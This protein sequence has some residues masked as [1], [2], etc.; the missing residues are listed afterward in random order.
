MY[1]C[2]MRK[3]KKARLSHLHKKAEIRAY[4]ITRVGKW[5]VKNN[6]QR[7]EPCVCVLWKALAFFH[8]L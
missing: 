3:K 2:D 4:S 7:K 1:S 6:R 8:I 5:C